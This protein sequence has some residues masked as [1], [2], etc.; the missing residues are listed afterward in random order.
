ME[1]IGQIIGVIAFF[2]T[3]FGFI[4]KDE[5]KL[6]KWLTIASC[7]WVV[8]FI[9]LKSYTGAAIVTTIAVRQAVSTYFHH[10]PEDFRLKLT[11]GFFVVNLIVAIITWQNWI[12]FFPFLA[13]SL[14]TVAMFLWNGRKMQKGMLTV[15][16]FWFVHNVFFMSFGGLAANFANGLILG[17]KVL[18]TEKKD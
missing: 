10:A 13:A 4:Q 17:Y 7:V 11:Y 9:F 6:K 5:V 16:G 15:E 14:A 18:K 3:V 2:V 8:H 12:S 1:I